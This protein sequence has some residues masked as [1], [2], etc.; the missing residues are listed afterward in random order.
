LPLDR[1]VSFLARDSLFRVP[2]LGSFLRATF[3][4][5]V[6][7]DAAGSESIRELVARMRTGF[8][9]GIFPEGT[10]TR[11]G[12]VGEFKPGFVA[13]LKRCDQPVYPVG[14]GGAFK[15]YPRG[16][17][18]VRPR[19]VCVVYGEPIDPDEWKSAAAEGREALLAFVRERVVACVVEAEAWASGKPTVDE[20]ALANE[21]P[22]DLDYFSVD[23]VA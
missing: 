8:V 13:L 15:A 17:W 18:F 5:P 23:E 10:R 14:I 20:P 4:L 16:A 19:Q 2:V 9:V 22:M 7:R 1:P 6:N 12:S 11:D 3:V 21:S